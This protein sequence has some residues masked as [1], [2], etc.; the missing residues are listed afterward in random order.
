LKEAIQETKCESI[1]LQPV[2]LDRPYLYCDEV[3]LSAE[4]DSLIAK[5]I[6]DYLT[7]TQ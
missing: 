6:Y 1:D 4:G 2:L 5:V 7:K 3:H